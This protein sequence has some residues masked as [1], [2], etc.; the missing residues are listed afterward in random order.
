MQSL[1]KARSLKFRIEEG[2]YYLC[3]QSK[4]ADQLCRYRIGINPGFSRRGS[5]CICVSRKSCLGGGSTFAHIFK[6]YGA[7]AR[8]IFPES[9]DVESIWLEINLMNT[10]PF[11]I[12]SVYRPP[13]TCARWIKDFTSQVEKA[14]SLAEEI[15]F[16]GDFNINLLSD[17]EQYRTW[18]HSFEAYDI[19]QMVIEPTRVTAKSA[20]LI[21]HIY[22]NRPDTITEC[23]VPA[24]ALSD[25]YPVC[26]TR[27]TSKVETSKRNHS[28]I[29][30][31]SF[32]NFEDSKFLDQLH[33]KIENFKCTQTYTN[34]NFS[35]WN[36]L[37]LSVLDE[38]APIK[39]KRVKRDT[40]PAWLNEEITIAQ[41]KRDYYHKKQDWKN[42]KHWR[43]CTKNRIRNAKR[44]FF[45]NAINEN[46]DNSFRWKHVKDI[47]GK[48]STNSLPTSINS[49]QGVLNNP[50]EII[51]EMNLFFATVCDRLIK[52]CLKC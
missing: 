14:A 17:D 21:D 19:A 15:H 8:T 43:N 10:K 7:F 38:H 40:K 41:R 12:G 30:Y 23:F 9:S 24:V 20:R 1:K 33:K 44:N 37:F 27:H 50:Q 51:D 49:R 4:G 5:I 34:L 22:M 46:K 29:K 11:L 13:N 45:E 39:E 28:S 26:F 35:T 18:S 52:E 3:S 2:M 48:S 16:L 42:Y 36:E 31:R 47:N 6:E 25:H 32:K